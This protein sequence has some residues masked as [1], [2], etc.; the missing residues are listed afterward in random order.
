M[1]LLE[2]L[3]EAADAV[4]H[5]KL[6]TI[7]SLLGMIIGTASVV[8]VMAAGAMMSHEFI[9]QA[10][11]IGA[12]LI[13]VYNNWEISDSQARRVFMSNRDVDAI[14]GQEKGSLVVRLNETNRNA[15]KGAVSKSISVRGID[16]GYWEMWPRDFSSGRPIT[17][18]DDD[19]L[20]KVCV[21]TDD[22]AA[23]FFPEGN[24]LG[25]SLTIGSFDYTVVG[26]IA[27]QEG[28][29]L[30]SDGSSTETAFVPYTVLERTF[31]W[32]WSGSPRVYELMIRAP[33]VASVASTASSIESYLTRMYG[34]VDGKCRFKVEAIEGALKAIRTIFAAV[35]GIIAFIAGISLFVSGIGIM[36][37][38]LVAVSER[39][40]EIGVRK[41]VGAKSSDIM[42]QF[43]MESLFICLA[44]GIVGIVLGMGIA[45]VISMV[46]KWSY[47]MPFNAPLVALVVSACVGLF[48]GL[49]P[50]KNAAALDPVTALTKE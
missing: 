35:S 37:V 41:A 50:A 43:L 27:R 30:M 8:A 19:E 16:P 36:N 15:V 45:R 4:S 13:V 25:S 18:A 1:R 7:L 48:F 40:R 22:Y 34:T 29:A 2:G 32:T 28:E 26:I 44:G 24:A 9:D 33:S 20:A 47:V 3:T 49:V 11:S 10:D 12:R 42:S 23:A 14:R 5:N 46:S 17:Q 6:R 38:M 21:L 31:D 39:T